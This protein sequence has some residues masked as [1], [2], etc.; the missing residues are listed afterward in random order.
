MCRFTNTIST[1]S[2]IR[3]YNEDGEEI[4]SNNIEKSISKV[5]VSVDILELKELPLTCKVTGRPAEGY[6]FTGRFPIPD[7]ALR[8]PPAQNT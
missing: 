1:D 3:L 6:G 4:V 5:R 2:N 7:R 8:W